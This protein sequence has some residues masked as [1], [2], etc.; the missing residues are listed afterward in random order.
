MDAV[1]GLGG[2][3]EKAFGA[4]CRRMSWWGALGLPGTRR[5]D[6]DSRLPGGVLR[7]PNDWVCES[8][9]VGGD[10]AELDTG[11]G[12]ISTIWGA[13]TPAAADKACWRDM[14]RA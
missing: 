4:I 12:D 6:M 14:R 7:D 5:L 8:A 2:R 13:G 10:M 11:R 3:C 9:E 1:D